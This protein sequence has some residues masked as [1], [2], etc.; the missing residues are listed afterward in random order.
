MFS[1]VSIIEGFFN[2]WTGQAGQEKCTS[3]A[4]KILRN[5]NE[6]PV[7][8]YLLRGESCGTPKRRE[9][10]LVYIFHARAREVPPRAEKQKVKSISSK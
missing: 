9:I 4:L 1:L 8:Y 6:G 3:R 2:W 5:E 10:V 7:V